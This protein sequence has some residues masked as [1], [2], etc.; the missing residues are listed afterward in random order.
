MSAEQQREWYVILNP[1]S[2]SGGGGKKWEEISQLLNENGIHFDHAVTKAKGDAIRLAKE[3]VLS[4]YR[5]FIA[6]GGDGTNNE[7]VNGLVSQDE[8]P[9][10]E[11]IH[12]LIPFGTGNDWVRTYG[13][14]Q[15]YHK[16]IPLIKRQR[17][18]V[19]DIGSVT[20]LRD[21]EERQRYFVNV[22]G[23]AYD[24]YI[25]MLS[26]KKGGTGKLI[27]LWLVVSQLFNYKNRKAAVLFQDKEVVAD[28]YSVNVGIC[29]YSGGGMQLVP[30]AVPDDGLLALTYD[31]GL[32]KLQVVLNTYRLFTGTIDRLKKVFTHQ[33]ESVR[34][35]AR[36]ERPTYLEVDG[37]FLGETPCEFSILPGVLNVIVP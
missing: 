33:V 7:V 16:W 31:T 14:P 24:G 26:D 30:H 20:Y 22:A 37:E 28:F 25:G 21:G 36:E 12:T 4:G 35:E 23:M 19:Q 18:L 2:G 9:M 27:Y 6:V 15:D 11:L 17:T 1:V 13:I 10:S 8:V 29:R 5:K 3:A 32:S 34:V